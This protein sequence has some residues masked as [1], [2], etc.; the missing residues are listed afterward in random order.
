MVAAFLLAVGALASVYI[1]ARNLASYDYIFPN[2]YVAGVNVGGMTRMQ[3]VSA[4]NTA[5]R[6]TY[7]DSTLVVE[8][9]DRSISFTPEKTQVALDVD[10]AVEKA[11]QYGR[12]GSVFS[13]AKAR[14]AAENSVHHIDITTD[15]QLDTDYIAQVIQQT[16][17]DVYCEKINATCN[18]D[19]T[20]GQIVIITG[21]N[22]VSLDTDT[23]YDLVVSAFNNN[24]FSTLY[25]DYDVDEAAAVD[26]DALYEQVCASAEDAAYDP[27]TGEVSQ[28]VVG[29]QFDLE[30]ARLELAQAGEAQQVIIYLEVLEPTVTKAELE[31]LLFRDV[32]STYSS[33]HTSNANRTTNLSLACE[34]IDGTVLQPGDVF[35]FNNIVG[36]R[37][38]ERGYLPAAIYVDGK[39]E[40]DTGGGVCQ[41]TSTVYCAALYANLEIVERL[42]HMYFVSYVPAGLDATVYWDNGIDFKFR[43]NTDYPIRIE[44]DVS[45]GYVNVTFY[46][47]NVDGTYVEMTTEQLSEEEPGAVEEVV[48]DTVASGTVLQTAYV[49]STWVSYRHVYDKN[50]NEIS[51]TKEAETEYQARPKKVTVHTGETLTEE[52]EESTSPEPS[53]SRSPE[54]SA[55]PSQPA[56]SASPSPS[57]TPTPTPSAT[58]TPTPSATPSTEPQP[59]AEPSTPAEPVTPVEPEQPEEMPTE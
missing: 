3:A 45:G 35:S 36:E 52:P 2:V 20:Q 29:Q 23:L 32:L 44:A 18:I 26:L 21:T 9:P 37:T 40:D 51:V 13:V 30:A 56:A 58:V 17:S 4:V 46:G 8:L 28:E 10:E 39:T 1:Y 41:V 47:T 38:K 48:D 34:A 27:E 16:A 54:A 43:N 5:V 11:Y 15:L 49:G 59:S 12:Q 6:E 7:A 14:K 24:D 33:P 55:T 31:E 53:E 50:G 19:L 57:A 25:F 42:E 22:G